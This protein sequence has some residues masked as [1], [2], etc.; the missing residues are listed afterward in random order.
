MYLIWLVLDFSGEISYLLSI[1]EPQIFLL[2]LGD[3]N[4]EIHRLEQCC[5]H[6]ET[7]SSFLSNNALS[8]RQ[9]LIFEKPAA[10]LVIVNHL[11]LKVTSAIT[12]LLLAL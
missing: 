6:L 4:E 3:L 10:H 11:Q 1:Q 2:Y 7:A 9:C 8:S 12:K 5:H